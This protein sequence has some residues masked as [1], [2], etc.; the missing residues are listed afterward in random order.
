MYTA[1]ITSHPIIIQGGMGV[2]VSSW[3]LARAVSMN[4][5]LGVISGTAT[6]VVMARYLQAGDPGGHYRR[7]MEHFPV[8][9]VA[10]RILRS[11]YIAGG[12]A[13]TAPFKLTSVPTLKMGAP[14]NELTVAGNFAEIW[15]AKEGHSG[16]VGVNFL[17]KI[18]L[19]TL[20]SLFG[21]M[22]AGAD[23]VLMGAGIP[24]SIP[25]ALDNLSQGKPVELRIDVEDCGP[26]DVFDS[27]FDPRSIFDGEPPKLK[28]PNF[29]AIIS[30]ATLAMALARKSNG[31]VNGFVIEGP[32]AGGHNAP[33]RGP[34][35]LNAIGEPIYGERDIPEL[36]KIKALGLPFWLAGSYGNRAKVKEALQLG[37]VGVQ[38]GTAFA[39]CRES[40]IDPILK[41]RALEMSRQGVATVYTDPV[42][43]PTGFPFKV[44]QMK[45]S[46][47]DPETY[48]KRTRICDL[49]YLRHLYR[50]QDGSVGYRCPSEPVEDYLKKGG[51]LAD[52][53][54]R[55]CVCNGL[56]G[57][58]GLAQPLADGTLE[59]MLMTAGD[60]AATV[61]SFLKPGCDSYG[62]RDV[63]DLLLG[64]VSATPS[65]T[66]PA[67]RL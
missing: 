49:G 14:L 60:D 39:F 67:P 3:Q 31:Q 64:K 43:S 47:S 53:V 36:D 22:L 41:A 23:Y 17:E 16:V 26:G 42:A 8:P 62:A 28:R 46:M 27:H 13:A 24:R 45:G 1:L 34:M 29:L 44:F 50:K 63:I 21:V 65:P 30:S 12:K 19:P 25:G 5:Q 11:H 54:G 9:S 61:A 2:G 55:K 51:A 32:T 57:T 48:A 18:Q 37:A 40:G 59:P 58:I 20:P 66:G 56:V 4:G 38:V 35:Q 6:G 7:A 52:T 33:P 10:E 15:L